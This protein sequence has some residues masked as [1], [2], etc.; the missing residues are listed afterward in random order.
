MAT[1]MV[2]QVRSLLVNAN[3]VLV[4]TIADMHERDTDGVSKLY[5][6]SYSVMVYL[7][8]PMLT[9]VIALVPLLSEWWLGHYE[10]RFVLFAVLLGIGWLVNILSAPAYFA[11][12][13]TGQLRWNVTGHLTQ[14]GLNVLLGV[15]LGSVWDGLGVVIGAATALITGGAVTALS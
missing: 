4:P 15:A 10:V 7:S 6:D 5:R 14:S 8:L 9:C 11:G 12:L 13:G 3:Q 1:R 2:Q